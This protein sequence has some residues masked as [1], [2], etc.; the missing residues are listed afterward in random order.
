[1]TA[2]H[3]GLAVLLGLAGLLAGLAHHIATSQPIHWLKALWHDD[4]DAL[5]WMPEEWCD[6]TVER[7]SRG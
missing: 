3:L 5:G 4:R 7:G 1:M 6:R 2:T